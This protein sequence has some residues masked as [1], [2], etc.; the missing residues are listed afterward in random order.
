MSNE[1]Q[2]NESDIRALMIEDH[3]MAQYGLKLLL[4]KEK[5]ISVC[6]SIDSDADIHKNI[7]TKKPTVIIMDL[8]MNNDTGLYI[9]QDIHENNPYLPILVYTFYDETVYALRVLKMGAKGYIMKSEPV[10]KLLKAVR[11]VSKGYVWVSDNLGSHI[12]NNL[13]ANNI[14]ASGDIESLTNRE[15]EVFKLEGKGLATDEIANIINVGYKT[16]QTYQTRIKD[17][18]GVTNDAQLR[19]RAICW[20][21]TEMMRKPMTSHLNEC[22]NNNE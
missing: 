7:S 4:E 2:I 10:D 18:L 15:L 14:G 19:H 13:N 11:W 3:P 9:V 12:M 8:N 1:T 22:N 21:Q 20:M 5:D 6:G 16:V 17:K